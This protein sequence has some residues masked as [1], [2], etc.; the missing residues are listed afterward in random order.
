MAEKRYGADI[1]IDIQLLTPQNKRYTDRFFCDYPSIDAYFQEAAPYDPTVV[2]YLFID[3]EEDELIACATISCSAI[4]NLDDKDRFSTI[5]SAMEIKF[6]AVDEKY[7][8]LPYTKNAK[9]TLSHYILIY[10]LK[11]M[12][13]LSHNSVGAAKVVLYSVP[14]AVR[15]YKRCDFKEFGD[16][17]FGDKGI[18]VDGCVPMYFDLN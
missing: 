8:H 4:F 1:P 2:T 15:F 7:K 9:L 10:M 11:M 6:F 5:L 18:F 17:M 16:T 13:D 12:Q 3:A 14:E